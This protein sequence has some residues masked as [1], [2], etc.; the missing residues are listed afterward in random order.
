MLYISE[1]WNQYIPP[2][3][4][5]LLYFGII[6]LILALLIA[7]DHSIT[8]QKDVKYLTETLKLAGDF[9]ESIDDGYLFELVPLAFRDAARDLRE[10]YSKHVKSDNELVVPMHNLLSNL[11]TIDFSWEAFADSRDLAI[12]NVKSQV[13]AS[14]EIF[15]KELERAEK[16]GFRNRWLRVWKC[17]V[18]DQP[19]G[20][21]FEVA[22]YGNITAAMENYLDTWH[23]KTIPELRHRLSSDKRGIGGGLLGQMN[24]VEDMWPSGRVWGDE[25]FRLAPTDEVHDMRLKALSVL[26]LAD[27]MY[28]RLGFGI[29]LLEKEREGR[30]LQGKFG[31]SHLKSVVGA[32]DGAIK[33]LEDAEWK[34]RERWGSRTE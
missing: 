13:Q 27:R 33:R 22:N 25:R 29:R 8:A 2:S 11:E 31:S 15:Q 19:Y 7:K 34:V 10:Y 18:L 5:K 17:A 16:G 3:P 26:G 1:L 6:Y 23:G 32:F 28:E 21:G 4:N 14:R 12:S 20:A 30:G 9:S 24:E